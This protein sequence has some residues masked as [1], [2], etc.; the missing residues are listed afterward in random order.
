LSL[1]SLATLRA[2]PATLKA[3]PATLKALPATLKALPATLKALSVGVP[4]SRRGR[5]LDPPTMM[6]RRRNRAETPVGQ[7]HTGM[8]SQQGTN[9]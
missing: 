2:L 6:N 1:A 3:L 8:V 5:S 9:V 4:T 7:T